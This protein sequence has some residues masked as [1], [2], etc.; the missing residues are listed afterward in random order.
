MNMRRPSRVEADLT[1]FFGVAQTVFDRSK[2][3]ARLEAAQT[4]GHDSEG[5]RIESTYSAWHREWSERDKRVLRHQDAVD[6]DGALEACP[7]PRTP[8]ES[9]YEPSDWVLRRFAVI[10]RALTQC[11]PLQYRALEGYFGETGARW[12]LSGVRPGRL[13]PVMTL[14]GAGKASLEARGKR[15]KTRDD[16]SPAERVASELQLQVTN[17]NVERKR[18]LAAAEAQARR[19]LAAALTQFGAD[20]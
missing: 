12:E 20:Q 15:L 8:V 9:G 14:V 16:G 3:G 19:L 11:S 13:V 1:W 5:R 4:F 18:L 10:S 6:H 7:R 17:P 2:E